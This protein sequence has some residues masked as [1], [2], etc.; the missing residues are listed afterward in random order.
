MGAGARLT[1]PGML[2]LHA[3]SWPGELLNVSERSSTVPPLMSSSQTAPLFF[4]LQGPAWGSPLPGLPSWISQPKVSSLL[5]PGYF[6][7]LSNFV[8][9][10]AV[11]H[12]S[13]FYEF[14]LPLLRDEIHNR[15][16]Q[17]EPDFLVQPHLQGCEGISFNLPY[18]KLRVRGRAG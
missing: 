15:K 12:C 2:C 14:T 7:T 5:P 6:T 8:V 10:H 16:F 3:C 13:L 17:T 18:V 11:V 4:N 9:T 1:G